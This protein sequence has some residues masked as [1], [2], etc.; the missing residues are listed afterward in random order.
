MRLLFLTPFTDLYA[1]LQHATGRLGLRAL[2]L[3]LAACA[4]GWWIYV[5]VHELM[6][7]WGA[8]LGGATVTRLDIDAVYG[9]RLLQRIFPYVRVGSAYAG[10][11]AGFD[12]HG[13]DFAYALAVFFPFVLTIVPGVPL[14]VRAVRAPAPGVAST[15]LLGLVLPLAWAPILSIGGDYY[16]LGAIAVSRVSGALGSDGRGWRGD[17]VVAVI[18]RTSGGSDAIGVALSL[19]LGIVLA[20]ATY[21]AGRLVAGV[22]IRHAPP[23]AR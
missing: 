15:S 17:D 11:L 7:A 13:S 9:A 4:A 21:A 10:Q 12:T 6:H 5:P 14:L 1:G 16:E 8:E 23:P 20:F 22:L 18:G 19:L 2:P 3:L